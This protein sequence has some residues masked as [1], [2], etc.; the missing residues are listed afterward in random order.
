MKRLLVALVIVIPL[1]E[2]FGRE[3]KPFDIRALTLYSG[4]SLAGYSKMYGIAT[5]PEL[6]SEQHGTTGHAAGLGHVVFINN[7]LS[8]DV[9]AQYARKGATL[10]W[11]QGDD[12]LGTWTYKLYALSY[13]PTVKYKMFSGSSPYVL[14]GCDIAWVFAHKLAE[15]GT[16]PIP[17]SNLNDQTK[18]LN[19]GLVVGVGAELVLKK[20]IPFLEIRYDA[21]LLNISK[22][23]E[24][25]TKAKT[26][27]LLLLA[28]IKFPLKAAE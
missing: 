7:R 26:R 3:A 17:W 28:G 11:F 13:T 15:S 16:I 5:F 24:Y 22:I 4:I 18:D 10:D 9:I 23:G 1:S 21:G 8:I 27:A 14:G 12:Y 19:I 25:L 2:A 20:W 6:R